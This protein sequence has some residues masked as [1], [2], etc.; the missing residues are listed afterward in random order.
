MNENSMPINEMFDG[1]KRLVRDVSD[2]GHLYSPG[3]EGVVAA[4]TSLSSADA[5]LYRGYEVDRLASA[6]TFPEVA[7]LILNR[8]LPTQEQYADFR[9]TMNE[10]STDPTVLEWVDTIPMS[11]ELSDVLRST[12]SML[13]HF[14]AQPDD[15][16][17]DAVTLL[18]LIH[19]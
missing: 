5:L 4:E 1:L 12:V 10:T 17:A 11:V 18:S 2:D 6:A 19:I 3:L 13:G 8:Q 16:S 15:V 9:S 14:D 7:W